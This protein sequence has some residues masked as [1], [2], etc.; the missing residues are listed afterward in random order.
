M[1]KLVK[2]VENPNDYKADE[3]EDSKVFYD[4]LQSK[5]HKTYSRQLK[6]EEKQAVKTVA[7][8]DKETG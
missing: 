2:V 6:K 1:L 8:V 7:I 3:V 5:M 4:L